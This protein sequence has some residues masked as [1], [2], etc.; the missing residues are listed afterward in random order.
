MNIFLKKF[1]AGYTIYN[2]FTLPFYDWVVIGFNNHFVWKCPTKKMLHFYNEHITTNHLD[3]G[4]GSGYYL[5]HACFSSENPRIGLMDMSIYSLEKSARRIRRYKPE[6]FCMNVLDPIK[7]ETKK[8][9][10]IGLNYLLHCVPGAMQ[11]KSIIF[12][13]LKALIEPDGV[14]FGSTILGKGVNNSLLARCMI[15][16]LEP[17]GILNNK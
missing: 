14:I 8:F 2:Q 3:V 12:K 1:K 6:I 17:S 9:D 7:V 16:L 11:P 4:V 13:H 15:R 5:D 10:S